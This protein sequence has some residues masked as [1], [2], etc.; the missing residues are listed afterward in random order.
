MNEFQGLEITAPPG[1]ME[2]APEA[3]RCRDP[4]TTTAI[5]GVWKMDG[6]GA[7]RRGHWGVLLEAGIVPTSLPHPLLVQSG[8]DALL[9]GR[10]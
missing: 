4:E 5:G 2:E 6:M 10:R 8:W 7:D 1:N 9:P 3:P